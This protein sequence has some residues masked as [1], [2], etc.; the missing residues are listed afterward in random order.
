MAPV[1]AHLPRLAR[2]PP[3]GRGVHR[4]HHRRREHGTR[5]TP[6]WP[7]ARHQ[8]QH[9]ALRHVSCAASKAASGAAC[10]L[11]GAR[12]GIPDVVIVIGR[13]STDA[14]PVDDGGSGE[15]G[16]R[17]PTRA[18]SPPRAPIKLRRYQACPAAP[19]CAPTSTTATATTA[20]SAGEGLAAEMEREDT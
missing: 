12:L 1:T 10:T 18:Q 2:R 17:G 13:I 14:L 15:H 9:R 5:P 11:T 3:S 4:R 19:S 16:P 7:R 6:E 8:P 20:R